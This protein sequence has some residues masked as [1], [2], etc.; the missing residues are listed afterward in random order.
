MTRRLAA[1]LA[2]SLLGAAPAAVRAQSAPA[3]TDVRV[4]VPFRPG[5][6]AP[7]LTVSE[8][9]S[10]SCWTASPASAG[11]PDAWRCLAGNRFYDPCF[12][13]F[14]GSDQ[15]VACASSPWSSDV[16]MLTLSGP[17]PGDVSRP[18]SPP[19]GPPWALELTTG[20]RCT[21]LTG[22]TWGVAGMRV[23]YGCPGDVAIVGD[24]DRSAAM[25]K[26]FVLRAGASVMSQVEVRAAYY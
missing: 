21:M 8:R 7:G 5:A 12:A 13:G 3:G 10:G 1:L 20:E 16:V 22:A 11:R 18:P 6:V 4:L 25:W 19:G 15:V 26:V 9:G 17:L 2:C 23:N 24:I 14:A